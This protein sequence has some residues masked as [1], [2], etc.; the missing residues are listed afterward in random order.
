MTKRT[1][2][3][4]PIEDTGQRDPLLHML[5]A[6]SDGTGDYITGME[7]TGQ[8]QLVNSD[9]LPTKGSDDPVLLELGFTFGEPDPGDPMFRPATLPPGWKRKGSEHAMW[10]Y[11][12]DERGIE[13]VAIFYKAA[14]YDRSAHMNRQNVGGHVATQAIYG[15]GPVDLSVLPKLTDEEKAGLRAAAEAYLKNADEHP[16][17][18]GDRAGR[19]RE[20]LAAVSA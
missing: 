19:A 5:G 20:V 15:D 4:S 17:I 11:I 1:D 7:A 6:M 10:S 13:R 9:R 8:R 16:G 12:E 14:Y 3:H 18:Y 2:G